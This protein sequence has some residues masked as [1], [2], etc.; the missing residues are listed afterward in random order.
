MNEPNASQ[1]AFKA[2]NICFQIQGLEHLWC[3]AESR[4]KKK[5]PVVPVP[6]RPYIF[7]PTPIIFSTR[8]TV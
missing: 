6:D 2:F 3:L 8:L 1:L 7:Q 5:L 4:H